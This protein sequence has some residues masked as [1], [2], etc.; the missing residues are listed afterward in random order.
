LVLWNWL[1]YFLVKKDLKKQFVGLVSVSMTC[2]ESSI[3]TLKQ[4]LR[5][6]TY[7]R[8]ASDKNTNV[9]HCHI[10]KASKDVADGKNG[11]EYYSVEV[12]CSNGTQYGLQAYGE[13]AIE[14][15]YEAHRIRC[16]I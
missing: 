8:K 6:G 15:Y 2:Y 14:L 9:T 12:T 4:L 3:E 5:L 13:E 16:R 1:G 11:T 10:T 7:N